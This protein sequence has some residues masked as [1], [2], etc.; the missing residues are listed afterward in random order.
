LWSESGCP[1]LDV[2]EL[3]HPDVGSEPGLG[4]HVAVFSDKLKQI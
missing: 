4:H 1:A 2:E 3:L